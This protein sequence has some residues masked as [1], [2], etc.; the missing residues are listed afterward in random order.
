MVGD[1]IFEFF[2]VFLGRLVLE[3]RSRAGPYDMYFVGLP[4]RSNERGVLEDIMGI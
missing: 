2:L 1:N 3:F 4:W